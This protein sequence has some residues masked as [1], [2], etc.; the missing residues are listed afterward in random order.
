MRYR[1]NATYGNFDLKTTS[2][3]FPLPRSEDGALQSVLG[4]GCFVGFGGTPWTLCRPEA[5]VCSLWPSL[6]GPSVRDLQREK[7]F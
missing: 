4:S 3:R 7:H 1:T 2:S 5:A 6:G